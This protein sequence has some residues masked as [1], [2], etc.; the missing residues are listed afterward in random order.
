MLEDMFVKSESHPGYIQ[1]WGTGLYWKPSD[2]TGCQF[3]RDGRPISLR[4]YGAFGDDLNNAISNAE[5][6]CRAAAAAW[7][8]LM[9]AQV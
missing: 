6:W 7:P 8:K 3:D 1:E 4:S 2:P 5:H 9:Q